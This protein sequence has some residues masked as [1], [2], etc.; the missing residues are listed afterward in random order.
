MKRNMHLHLHS[1]VALTTMLQT[2]FLLTYYKQDAHTELNTS[3]QRDISTGIHYNC[4]IN[5]EHIIK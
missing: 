1:Q 5:N 4:S 2:L 3:I